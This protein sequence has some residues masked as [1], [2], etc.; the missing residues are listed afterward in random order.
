MIIRVVDCE[1]TGYPEDD[2]VGLVEI[3]WYDL[4]YEA[5]SIGSPVTYFVNPGHPIP[6]SARAIHHISDEDVAGAMP[7]DQAAALLLKDLREGDI[8][9]AHNADFEKVFIEFVEFARQHLPER[10]TELATA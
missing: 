1:T 4:D 10:F 6:P 2:P 5:R 3:G 9:C 8:L 7:P